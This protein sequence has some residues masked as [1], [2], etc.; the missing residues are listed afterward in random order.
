[1]YRYVGYTG[2]ITF[3]FLLIASSG[4]AQTASEAP[5]G[6]AQPTAPA[7]PQLTARQMMQKFVDHYDNRDEAT[8]MQM[9]LISKTGSQRNRRMSI[10]RRTDEKDLEKIMIRFHEPN[11]IRGTS[12]LTWEQAAGKDDLQWIYLPALKKTKQISG[13]AK[14][15]DFVGSDF[16]YEDLRPEKLDDFNYTLVGAQDG[17]VIID[18]TPRISDSGYSR[19]RVWLRQD[20]YFAVGIKYYDHKGQFLKKMSVS[21]LVNVAGGR[22]RANKVRM[23]N[24]QNGHAT[25]LNVHSRQLDTGLKEAA[26][27]KRELEKGV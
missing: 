3:T 19:R 26:F 15:D 17:R 20:N 14:K 12:L 18:A 6:T 23:E 5:A 8:K 25:E 16:T 1:M 27:T 21:G 2:I 11:D 9:V 24:V 22:V 4:H 10:K 7:Q 13:G